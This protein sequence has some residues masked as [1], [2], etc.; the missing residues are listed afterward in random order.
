LFIHLTI[1]WPLDCIS[2]GMRLTGSFWQD[3]WTAFRVLSHHRGT[4]FLCLLSIALGI[5]LTTGTF[6]LADAMFLRPMAMER[7]DEVLQITSRG[8]DGRRMMYGW[9]DCQDMARAG[10]GLMEMAA[11]Q[12]R[13][14]MLAAGDDSEEIL[15]SPVTPNF[16]SLLGVRVALGRSL[17]RIGCR[18]ASRSNRQPS[19]ATPVRRRPQDCGQNCS[20]KRAGFH[21]NGRHAPGVRRTI[22]RSC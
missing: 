3:V 4:T 12:R 2:R 15:A 16:F 17:V 5:G 22:A 10:S 8:D 13:G 19:M 6:S 20:S 9:P 18:S 11:Y 21:R 7:P 1:L 14:A